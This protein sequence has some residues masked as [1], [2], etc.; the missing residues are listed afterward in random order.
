MTKYTD[1]ASA[2]KTALDSSYISKTDIVDNLTTND[3]TKALSAKQGKALYDM[4][5]GI[6]NDMLS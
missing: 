2:I 1:E 6:E 3:N 4:I 5:A